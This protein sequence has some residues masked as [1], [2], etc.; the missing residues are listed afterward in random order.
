MADEDLLPEGEDQGDIDA[1]IVEQEAEQVAETETEPVTLED[2]ASEM[3][4]TPQDK[5]RGD[6]DKWRPAKD[7]LRTTVDVNRSLVSKLDGVERQV[8]NMARTSAEITARS[9]AKERERILAERNEAFQLGDHETF[10]KADQEL[11]ALPQAPVAPPPEAIAFAE[12]NESWFGKDQEATAWATNRAEQLFQQ[13]IG[14]AR[15]VAIVEREAKQMFPEL[16]QEDKPRA[17]PAP[18]NT[19]GNRGGASQKKGFS[20]LPDEVKKA[21]LDYEKRGVCT[22]EEYAQTYYE[23]EA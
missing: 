14:P 18:L 23:E 19:P 9:I 22:K 6:P 16:F 8:A 12:R 13:G 15:Q 10:N 7:F 4:W 2:L 3:G 21:A 11:K 17:K 20:T 1:P 5:W